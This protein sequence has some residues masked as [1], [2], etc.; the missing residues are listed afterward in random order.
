MPTTTAD[1]TKI[2]EGGKLMVWV[3]THSIAM[4]T[5]HTLTINT[6][7]SEISNKDIASGDWAASKIKKFSWEVSSDNMYTKSAYLKLYQQMI[8]KTP[9]LLTFG[10]S[11]QTTL[12][13]E[14]GGYADW[15]WLAPQS[16]TM[17]NGDFYM[18]GNA[19]ITS[20]DVQAPNDDNA[21]FSV[22]FTGTGEL[23]AAIS[24]D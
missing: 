13:D 18:Q 24:N 10:T 8:S 4:A 7:T 21:T 9:V 5:N 2:I 15:G 23:T 6:E 19:L 16:G 12:Q 22:T 17:V 3:G 14:T 1:Q 11:P 20:L